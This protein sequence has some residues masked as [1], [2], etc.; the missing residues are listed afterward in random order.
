MTPFL[1]LL[2]YIMD[3][4]IKH[5][6]LKMKFFGTIIEHSLYIYQHVIHINIVILMDHTILMV[7]MY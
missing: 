3:V 1:S 6:K 4:L 2:K 7:M 5:I